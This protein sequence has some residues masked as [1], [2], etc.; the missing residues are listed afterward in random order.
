M[1]LDTCT[2]TK[3][4]TRIDNFTCICMMWIFTDLYGYDTDVAGYLRIEAF[5]MA[6]ATTDCVKYSHNTTNTV[7]CGLVFCIYPYYP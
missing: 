6:A 2:G 4:W 5:A 1:G 7:A 3:I